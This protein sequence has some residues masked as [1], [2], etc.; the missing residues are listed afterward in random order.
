MKT[1]LPEKTWSTMRGL[2]VDS[3]SFYQIKEITGLVGLPIHKLS[4]LQQKKDGGATKGILM[5][6]IDKLYNT[7]TIDEK[8]VFLINLIE[9][10][11]EKKPS[12][13]F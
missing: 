5:D 6:E 2:I 7:L 11:L 8:H 12:P 1:I 10:F 9:I 3:F 13:S 4:Q